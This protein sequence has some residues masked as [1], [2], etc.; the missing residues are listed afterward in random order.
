MN[1]LEQNITNSFRLAKTDIVKLQQN[2]IE[3]RSSREH[4]VR[5]LAQLETQVQ[6]LKKLKTQPVKKVDIQKPK[7]ITKTIVTRAAPKKKTFIASK[8]GKKFHLSN[9]PYAQNIKPKMKLTFKSRITPLNAGYKPC[10][11]VK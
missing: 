4:L 11:C 7:I 1:Q 6:V 5:K 3:L 2:V 9:C 8:E 10:N